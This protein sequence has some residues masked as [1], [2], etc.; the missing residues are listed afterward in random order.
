MGKRKEGQLR[1]MASIESESLGLG[2]RVTAHQG[3][4]RGSGGSKR[5]TKLLRAV[6]SDGVFLMDG[7]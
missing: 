6:Q 3:Y 2:R 5:F 4:F 1:Y 7:E